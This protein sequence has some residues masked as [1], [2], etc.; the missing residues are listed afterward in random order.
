MDP[1]VSERNGLAFAAAIA[2][3]ASRFQAGAL[4]GSSLSV[5]VRRPD[6]YVQKVSY[7]GS[8]CGVF[9]RSRGG[10][11]PQLCSDEEPPSNEYLRQ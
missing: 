2:P 9:S 5:F 10:D 6:T 1:E 4:G 3:L 7:G 8:C 11:T